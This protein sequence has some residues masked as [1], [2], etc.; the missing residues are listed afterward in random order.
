MS[1]YLCPPMKTT[2][3]I[4]ENF[5]L[6]RLARACAC[7]III[8]GLVVLG[9]CKGELAQPQG[10]EGSK[11]SLAVT[12]EPMRWVVERVAGQDWRVVSVVPEGY[13]PEDYEPTPQTLVEV[14]DAAA[15]LKVG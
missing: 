10:S 11:G 9:A 5:R 3:A 14:S 6:S 7:T 1:N 12:I 13:N 4:S 15:Y 8:C 2:P